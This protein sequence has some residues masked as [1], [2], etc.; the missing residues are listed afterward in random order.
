MTEKYNV[1]DKTTSEDYLEELGYRKVNTLQDEIVKQFIKQ[2]NM[3]YLDQKKE[4]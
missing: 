4:D 2:I 3:L 1:T